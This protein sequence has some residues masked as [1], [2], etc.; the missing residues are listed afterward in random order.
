MVNN[1]RFCGRHL[2]FGKGVP[3]QTEQHSPFRVQQPPNAIALGDC[4]S[5]YLRPIGSL[6]P[7]R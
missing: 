3:F 4:P 6:F 2:F 1:K 7:K 5:R